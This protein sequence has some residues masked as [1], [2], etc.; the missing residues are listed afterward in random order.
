[1][2]QAGAGFEFSELNRLKDEIEK[3]ERE[4]EELVF[5]LERQERILKEIRTKLGLSEEK[6]EKIINVDN[7]GWVTGVIFWGTEEID[8]EVV[9]L[10]GGLKYL[11]N[12]NLS[13]CTNITDIAPLAGLVNLEDLDLSHNP[14]ESVEDLANLNTYSVSNFRITK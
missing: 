3:K 14:S 2:S 10:I 1:M 8:D 11:T 7:D 6:F 4:F 13:A 5:T 9:K 12:L